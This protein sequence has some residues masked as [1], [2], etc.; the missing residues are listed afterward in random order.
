MSG[1]GS[2]LVHFTQHPMDAVVVEG[3]SHTLS[4]SFSRQAFVQWYKDGE[5]LP[6]AT[7][8]ILSDRIKELQ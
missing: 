2:S 6:G 8:R 1:L 3:H 5:P 7:N 4:V